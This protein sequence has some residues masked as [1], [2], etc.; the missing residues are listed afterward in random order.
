MNNNNNTVSVSSLRH[1]YACTVDNGQNAFCC[2]SRNG[3]VVILYPKIL[4]ALNKNRVMDK[5]TNQIAAIRHLPYHKY[6]LSAT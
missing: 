2:R 3:Y 6:I 4:K 5:Y 1:I